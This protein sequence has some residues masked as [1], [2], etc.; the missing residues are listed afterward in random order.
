MTRQEM[1]D[2]AVIGLRSQGWER[3][4]IFEGAAGVERC[5]YQKRVGDSVQRCAWGWVDQSLTGLI[6]GTVGNL[7]ERGIGLAA[8]LSYAEANWADNMQAA[9]DNFNYAGTVV[10]FEAPPMEQRFREFAADN[11]LIWPEGA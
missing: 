11:D 10:F 7:R 4:S 8:D 9:H 3:C 1:F 2:K 5:V 6:S